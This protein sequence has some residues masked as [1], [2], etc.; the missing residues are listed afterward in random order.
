MFQDLSN[1]MKMNTYL[2][3]QD[4]W[5]WPKLRC[6][7]THFFLPVKELLLRYTLPHRRK[8]SAIGERVFWSAQE[9]VS[10]LFFFQF[11][12]FQFFYRTN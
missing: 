10:S 2:D 6:P 5:F 1:Y 7:D 4:P 9:Q 12:K 8:V 3:S 11:S